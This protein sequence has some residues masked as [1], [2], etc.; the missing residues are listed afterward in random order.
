M[1]LFGLEISGNTCSLDCLK[2]KKY[3]ER[4]SNSEFSFG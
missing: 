4:H 1:S 3:E 2:G